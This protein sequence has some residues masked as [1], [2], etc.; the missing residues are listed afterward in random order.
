VA[1]LLAAV[2]P[3]VAELLGI[4][5][6]GGGAFDAGPGRGARIGGKRADEGAVALELGG[7]GAD[8]G[9]VGAG[10]L[11]GEAGERVR[12]EAHAPGV[13]EIVGGQRELAGDLGELGGARSA[14]ALGRALG[15]ARVPGAEGGGRSLE[16]GVL[17]GQT[18]VAGECLALGLRQLAAGSLVACAL[19]AGALVGGCRWG[20]GRRAR[21]ARHGSGGGRWHARMRRIG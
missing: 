5:V 17:G 14:V 6:A 12:A 7:D 1:Q 3:R 20:P 19:L 8:V 13:A 4:E 15:V 2:A 18:L 21:I 16:R 9:G 11:A 10:V